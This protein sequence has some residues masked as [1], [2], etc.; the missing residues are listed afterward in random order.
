MN[1]LSWPLDSRIQARSRV[2]LVSLRICTTAGSAG[3]LRLCSRRARRRSTSPVAN[4]TSAMSTISPKNRAR[5]HSQ[6]FS[7]TT[8]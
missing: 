4:P 6:R 8:R 1:T 3:P 7:E 2:G 5:F